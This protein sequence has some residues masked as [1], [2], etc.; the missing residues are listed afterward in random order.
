MTAFIVL[1]QSVSIDDTNIKEFAE[2]NL[3]SFKVPTIWRVVE[4]LPR[5]SLG[6]IQKAL[7]KKEG[8]S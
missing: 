5:D 8:F 7:L 4:S 3:A 1:N 6:K 2:N